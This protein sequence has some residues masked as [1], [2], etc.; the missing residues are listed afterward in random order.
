MGSD[1][2]ASNL[3]EKS[4]NESNEVKGTEKTM[5]DKA[6]GDIEDEKDMGED[7]LSPIVNSDEPASNLDEKSQEKFS[8]EE[9]LNESNQENGVSSDLKLLNERADILCKELKQ[10]NLEEE[11]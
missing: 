10:L 7:C 8:F 11:E 9:T 6:E 1:E 5:L 4:L 3:D 2:P